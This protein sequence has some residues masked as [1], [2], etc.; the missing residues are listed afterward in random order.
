MDPITAALI[1]GAVAGASSGASD[2]VSQALSDA[3]AGLKAAVKTRLSPQSKAHEAL[4]KLEENPDSK[5]WRGDLEDHL[6]HENFGADA[7]LQRLAE[8]LQAAL[9]EAGVAQSSVQVT[10]NSTNVAQA[11][12]GGTA[13]VNN[14]SNR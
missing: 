13:S 8:A 14:T 5:G 2:V 1:A 9:K 7:D 11:S 6:S 10:T 12:T 4:E 3:Y